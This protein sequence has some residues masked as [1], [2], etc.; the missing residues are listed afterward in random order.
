MTSYTPLFRALFLEC[1]SIYIHIRVYSTCLGGHFMYICM[2]IYNL[3]IEGRL[4]SFPH[5]SSLGDRTC[6][7]SDLSLMLVLDLSL[8]V[9]IV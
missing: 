1:L 3:Y 8:Y 4:T 9:R 6:S 5:T 2:Y 7:L